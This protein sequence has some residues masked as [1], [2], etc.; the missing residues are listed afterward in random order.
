MT[1]LEKKEYYELEKEKE[2]IIQR[3]IE[4]N[5]YIIIKNMNGKKFGENWSEK[6][7]RSKVPNLHKN[8]G[9]GHDLKSP[10]YPLIELKSSRVDFEHGKWTM[11]QIHVQEA[12]A[13]LF[14]WYD[15]NTG[16]QIISFMTTKQL[17]DECDRSPQHQADVDICCT[18]SN[19]ERNLKAM[20]RH[21][22]ASWEKLNEV[23]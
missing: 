17:C 15:C 11:N 13:F 6:Y 9:K 4:L 5:P 22:I 16:E 21:K 18:V 14:V 12:D 1:E 2:R 20:K 7:V 23:V 3:Q 8:N 10:K 19:T